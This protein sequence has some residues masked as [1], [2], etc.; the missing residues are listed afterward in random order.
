MATELIMELTGESRVTQVQPP[1]GAWANFFQF[2]PDD[3]E[4]VELH[5]QAT[6]STIVRPVVRH[7]HNWTVEVP[8][9]ACPRPALIRFRKDGA[10][11]YTYWVYQQGDT[12]YQFYSK[13][14]ERY[15]HPSWIRG[16]RFIILDG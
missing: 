9:S 4:P 11:S 16:R 5:S 2:D 6:G 8:E 15:R 12:E 3:P 7:D 10:D 13:L 1:W 14:L